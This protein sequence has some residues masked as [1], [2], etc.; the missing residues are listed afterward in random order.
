M[1]QACSLHCPTFA[2]VIGAVGALLPCGSSAVF[3]VWVR[4]HIRLH[5]LGNNNTAPAWLQSKARLALAP[6][7][8]MLQPFV[9]IVCWHGT[10]LVGSVGS[11]IL[12]AMQSMCIMITVIWGEDRPQGNRRRSMRRLGRCSLLLC[13]PTTG[14]RAPDGV[15]CAGR[16]VT[17]VRQAVVAQVA[18]VA[19]VS[20]H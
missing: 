20:S 2:V 6:M 10:K 7:Q 4:P 5:E 8:V 16:V 19:T 11:C 3:S 15:E 14:A 1:V 12:L 9:T 13:R 18:W 17:E